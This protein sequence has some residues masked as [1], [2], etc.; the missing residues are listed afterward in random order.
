M[1]KEYEA[2]RDSLLKR[3][4]KPEEA[5]RIAAA[6]YNKQVYYFLRLDEAYVPHVKKIVAAVNAHVFPSNTVGPRSLSKSEIN[7]VV[8]A[9]L[10]ADD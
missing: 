4:V 10:A 9:V 2:I 6:T 3:G 8:N 7:E 5:K 1:P